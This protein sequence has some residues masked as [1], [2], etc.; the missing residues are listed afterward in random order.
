V[1]NYT[2]VARYRMIDVQVAYRAGI[3]LYRR[4]FNNLY[5]SRNVRNKYTLTLP[6]YECNSA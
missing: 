3:V 6:T 5:L 1:Q 2:V 4:G